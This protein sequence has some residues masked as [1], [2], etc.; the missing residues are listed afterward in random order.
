MTMMCGFMASRVRTVSL[1]V[2]PFFR[3]ETEELKLIRSALRRLAAI[4][5]E[6]RVR[7]EFSKNRLT[8]VLP[9]EGRHFLDVAG[10]DLDEGLGRLQDG[11]DVGDAEVLDA[12]QV[13]L[14]EGLFSHLESL[15]FHDQHLVLAVD[16]LE[17]DLDPSRGARWA[18]T[19]P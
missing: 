1:R 16:F 7:V 14:A 2:S 18:G 10:G 5:N 9:F 4:S 12:Q 13:V 11:L 6:L 8:T 19:C 17:H 3:L 15:G